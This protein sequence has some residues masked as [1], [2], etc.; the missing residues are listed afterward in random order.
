MPSVMLQHCHAPDCPC[1]A[2]PEILG[3]HGEGYCSW[4]CREYTEDLCNEGI[5]D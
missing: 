2:D 5:D 3:C 4:E 1:E